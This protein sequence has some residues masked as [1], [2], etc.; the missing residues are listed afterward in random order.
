MRHLC[1]QSPQNSS[2]QMWL[3]HPTGK[4]QNLLYKR[5]N[6]GQKEERGKT[7]LLGISW[8]TVSFFLSWRDTLGEL[9]PSN[10]I[11]AEVEILIFIF[12]LLVDLCYYTFS[13]NL[14]GQCIYQKQFWAC[15]SVPSVIWAV[16]ESGLWRSLLSRV[17]VLNWL[18]SE[19][20][21]HWSPKTSWST[22]VFQ[23]WQISIPWTQQA[24][25]HPLCH[26]EHL[27]PSQ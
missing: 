7:P 4:S 11:G 23:V 2:C 10:C 16:C 14:C 21:A 9:C 8:Q 26:G 18:W 3:F 27:R 22:G 25:R 12:I 13:S 20:T 17:L 1:D 5:G 24:V 6:L 19:I 15:F